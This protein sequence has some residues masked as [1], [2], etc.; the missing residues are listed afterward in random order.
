MEN[1]IYRHVSLLPPENRA[2]LA[3]GTT[4]RGAAEYYSFSF[5]KASECYFLDPQHLEQLKI[6]SQDAI[7]DCG[8]RLDLPDGSALLDVNWDRDNGT[9]GK[10]PRYIDPI[11]QLQPV[12]ILGQLLRS[13]VVAAVIDVYIR[14]RLRQSQVERSVPKLAL[15]VRQP[16]AQCACVDIFAMAFSQLGRN[17]AS[18]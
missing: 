9:S 11:A 4:K 13:P 2:I 1:F 18:I 14:Y 17:A 3:E 8:P 6:Y 7:R 10:S 16:W 12:G 5:A 15:V